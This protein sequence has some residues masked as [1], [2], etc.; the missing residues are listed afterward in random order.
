LQ[1]SANY[2]CQVIFDRFRGQCTPRFASILKKSDIYIVMVPAN[3]TD[4]LQPLDISVNKAVK[5]FLR[6]IGML[7][8]CAGY[9]LMKNNSYSQ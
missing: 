5:V 6:N 8:V 4:Q 3:C 7:S 9:V 1:L 2:P